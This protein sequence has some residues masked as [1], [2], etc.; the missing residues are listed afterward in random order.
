MKSRIKFLCL[1]LLINVSALA[2]QTE[3]VVSYDRKS[4]WTK[5][6]ARLTFLSQEQK[7]RAAQT[8]KNEDEDKEKM[9]LLFTPTE[10]VYTYLNDQGQTEDGNYSWR[11]RDLLLYR[12]YDKERKTEIEEMLG[13]TYI[14]DDSLRT[15]T[16]RILDQIKEVAG[17]I[18]MKAETEDPIKKYKVTAWFAQDIPVSAGPERYSGLPGLIL[19]LDINGGDVIIEATKVEF[20]PV[21]AE[22]KLPKLK[23]KKITSADYEK[24][25]KQH[26]A[27]SITA[28]RNP[29][30]SI[31][32]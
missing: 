22:I 28:H 12:N 1:C 17:H 29:Y 19:E 23:G 18:C 10:S 25:I 8:W 3:G 11:N 9:K 30:W 4:Y 6:I 16:W 32:Y 21:A 15:P 26:I 24:M 2:Q 5:I 13:R 20:K 7:D 31:R 14:V 27:E